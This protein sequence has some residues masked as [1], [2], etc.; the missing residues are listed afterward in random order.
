[1]IE[2]L[3]PSPPHVVPRPGEAVWV[4]TLLFNPKRRSRPIIGARVLRSKV[5]QPH[6]DSLYRRIWAGPANGN[7]TMCAE[8]KYHRRFHATRASARRE[9]AFLRTI[10]AATGGGMSRCC[11]HWLYTLRVLARVYQEKARR[12]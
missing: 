2:T 11:N 4:V 7:V 10:V 5:L 12:P 1:M 3:A 6:A 9:A 8:S